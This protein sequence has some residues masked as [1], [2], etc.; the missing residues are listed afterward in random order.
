M[1]HYITLIPEN[2]FCTEVVE[3]SRDLLESYGFEVVEG[4]CRYF[5]GG[6]V[7]DAIYLKFCYEEED[8]WV[9]DELRKL[10]SRILYEEEDRKS[11]W[12]H[13]PHYEF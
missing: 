4:D 12:Y 7:V 13:T 9:R 11:L 5:V 1:E 2:R 8:S 10:T 6:R 3:K